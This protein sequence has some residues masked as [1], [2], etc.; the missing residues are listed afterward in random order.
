MN[1][2]TLKLAGLQ[3]SE[4]GQP[5][6]LRRL[7]ILQHVYDVIQFFLVV[8]DSSGDPSK[9]RNA[10]AGIFVRACCRFQGSGIGCRSIVWSRLSLVRSMF[11]LLFRDAAR[12]RLL[13]CCY[14]KTLVAS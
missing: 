3:R 8:A 1:L 11:N 9:G 10:L 2:T 5:Y 13:I 12:M 7:G 14:I 4:R 6:G